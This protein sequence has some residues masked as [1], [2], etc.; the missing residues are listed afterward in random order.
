MTTGGTESILMVCKAYRDRAVDRGVSRPEMILP[1]TAHPA[2][3]KA[4]KYFCIRVRIIPVDPL[5]LKADV[6]AMRR[7]IN[8]ST[9]M[10]C[11]SR[12]LKSF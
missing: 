6:K 3:D 1:A 11:I 5:T 12:E 4:A 2:F 9:C 8:G 10:V 7:A